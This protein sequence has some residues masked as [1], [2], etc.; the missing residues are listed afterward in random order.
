[1]T[2]E[3]KDPTPSAANPLGTTMRI[4]LE[5]IEEA[6]RK[7]QAEPRRRSGPIALPKGVVA[8]AAGGVDFQQLLQSIYDAAIITD[9]NGRILMVNVRANQFFLA[10]PG[11]LT[12]ESVLSL[13]GS[14]DESLLPTINDALKAN[15]F[16]LM[17]AICP[18]TDGTSFAA[19]ISVNRLR[20]GPSDQLCFFFRDITLRKEQ[21]ERL[22]TGH[23]ALQNS[24]SGLVIAGLDGRIKYWNPAFLALCALTESSQAE[25][26][27][28]REFLRSPEAVDEIIAATERGET[29]SGELEVQRPDGSTFFGQ[30]AAAANVNTEGEHVG[31]VCS[32]LDV[33]LQKRAQQQLES[34]AAALHE[35]NAQMQE[36]LDIASE[37]HRMLLP[38]E[39]SIFPPGAA[40]CDAALHIRHLYSPSGTIGGDFFDIRALSDHELGLFISDVMGHGTRA[41]LVVATVRGLIEQL[42]PIAS[43]PGAFMTELNATYASIFKHIGGT[44]IFSTAFYAVIDT[45]TGVLRCANASQPHPYVLRRSV[46]GVEKLQIPRSSAL[47]IVPDARYETSEFLLAAR[48]V[49]LLY[50]DGISEVEDASGELYESERLARTLGASMEKA[51]GE[52]LG[53]MLADA[54]AFSGRENFEDDICLLAVEVA[55]LHP[56]AA[57][58]ED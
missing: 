34:Y 20:L 51:P 39:F 52:L 8:T 38:T 29:W 9:L 56:P 25:D 33:T 32:M 26:R 7:A 4:D 42:R 44:L 58:G 2:N 14:A 48:D 54:R 28:L 47:G 30:F 16:V 21:E 55:R 45:R 49:L 37:L 19:E 12:H 43:D 40:E 22:R 35:A 10:A 36:D 6:R 57:S 50:T 13:I 53:A 18:R 46:A 31:I 1:M 41:A 3:P 11:Q 23:T 27:D 15:R 24:S 17:Q 5:A